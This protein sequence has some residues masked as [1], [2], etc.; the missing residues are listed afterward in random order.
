[1]NIKF[2]VR[3]LLLALPVAAIISVAFILV[4]F[5]AQLGRPP[6]PTPLPPTILAPR[7]ELP[8]GPVGLQGWARYRG[9]ADSQ[10]VHG[11]LI[12]LSDG[13]IVGVT[14]AHGF[15]FSD[16]DHPLQQIALG[17]PGQT[18]F[19][20]EFDRLRGQPGQPRTSGDMTVDYLLLRADQ[21]IDSS[22]V[23]TPDS[24]GAPQPGERVSLFG[25]S[26]DGR[27]SQRVLEGTVQSVGDTAVWV[28]MDELFNPNGMSGSPFV[29]QHTGQ[30]VGMAIAV[31]PRGNRLLLG[32]H[33]IGSIV[34]L[35]ES[36][37]V[38]PKISEYR[39]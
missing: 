11:F 28:L 34:Q 31:S 16:A 32:V 29:S 30:V 26:G 23:L 15:S 19:V 6:D 4:T 21:P 17:A 35:A 36:A 14:P 33:P 20:V 22:F 18:D 39:R 10:V 25:C 3:G 2:V 5:R 27:G 38:F 9:K 1:M 24:R 37:A 7:G 12:R 8:V 13:E